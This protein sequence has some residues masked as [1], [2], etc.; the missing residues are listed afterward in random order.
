MYSKIKTSEI[1]YPIDL[2]KYNDYK[3]TFVTKL[4]VPTEETYNFVLRD[5]R[6][7]IINDGYGRDAKIEIS[8]DIRNND[9]HIAAG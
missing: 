8:I 9:K 6:K 4:D 1:I 7:K 2:T 3:G 5:C